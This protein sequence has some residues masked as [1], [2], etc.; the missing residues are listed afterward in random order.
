MTNTTT[1]HSTPMLLFFL[2][3]KLTTYKLTL[4][5]FGSQFQWQKQ[6]QILT[7][8]YAIHEDRDAYYHGPPTFTQE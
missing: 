4:S 2:I 1:Q 8:E 6:K 7:I 3:F 5:H